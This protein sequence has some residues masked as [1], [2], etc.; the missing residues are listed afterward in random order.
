MKNKI[1][2]ITELFCEWDTTTSPGCSLAVIKDG[3]IVYKNGYGMANLEH[4][5]TNKPSSVF[6]IASVSKQFA[7]FC[8]ALLAEQG[9]LSIEDDV[10]TYIPELPDYGHTIRISHLIHHTSGL[11]DFLELNFISGRNFDELITD[12]DAFNLIIRQKELN[13]RPGERY[14]YCNSGYFLLSVI[15]KRVS[16]KTMR[17]F[18]EENIFKP[19]GMQN[20]HFHDSYRE[21]VPNRATGYSPLPGGSPA[22][23][24]IN[25][26]GLE[27]VG[28]GGIYSTIED[29]YLWDQNYY[30]NKLGNAS[31]KLIEQMLIPGRFNDGT[32]QEYA[33]GLIVKEQN[34]L[35]KVRHAGGYGGYSA[36]FLQFPEKEFSVICLSNC[37][38]LRAPELSARVAEIFI[39]ELS[40]KTEDEPSAA[41]IVEKSL[42]LSANESQKYCGLFYSSA[43]EIVVKVFLEEDVLFIDYMGHRLLLKP[44]S[45]LVFTTSFDSTNLELVYSKGAARFLQEIRLAVG[46][47]DSDT[48]KRI[49]SVESSKINFT[50]LQGDYYC[51]E[52]SATA[53]LSVEKGYKL[54]LKIGRHAFQL[55]PGEADM[56]QFDEGTLFVKRKN[57]TVNAF[58]LNS[59]RVKTILFEKI[60]IN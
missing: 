29:L 51:Q 27:T 42:I 28:S 41:G 9:K 45:D 5:I 34:G 3:T 15:V 1:R 39:P 20:T 12:E 43:S 4:E 35:K 26:P 46:Q 36:E 50:E 59:G 58:V 8:I 2:Q 24:F 33:F 17:C 60:D 55:E 32:R 25:V 44:Q 13:F 21:P 10:C 56:F 54:K 48:L 52:L 6:Y 11:R 19:L 53:V 38:T 14:L 18:A 23:Y 40:T 22:D 31:Q 49:I 47:A 7:A 37:G 57:K 30:H 16:G